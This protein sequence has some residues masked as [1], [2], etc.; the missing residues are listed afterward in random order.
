[1][2]GKIT[3]LGVTLF[4]FIFVSL[5]FHLQTKKAPW[6]DECYS[7]YGVWHDSFSEFY[8][9]MLTGINFSPPLYFLF[10]FCIQLV[11]PTSI[12]QLRIQSL[13]FIIIGIVLSFLL[14]RRFFGAT[15]AFVVTTLVASQSNL[16]LSQAQEARH[17]AMFFACGAWVLYIQSLNNLTVK[18]YKWF[19]FL[20]H[21]CLCQVHYIGI[22]F[23]GLVG[24]SYLTSNKDKPTIHRIPFPVFITWIISLP[25][26]LLLLSQQSSHLGN[27]PKPNGLSNL[28]SSYNDS[29]LFLTIIIPCLALTISS[30][31]KAST[32]TLQNEETG[33]SR[34]IMITSFLWILVPLLFWI[35]SHITPL[36]L[37][38]DRYFIPKEAALIFLVGFG[39]SFIFQKLTQQKFKSIFVLGTFGLSLVLILISTKRAAFGLN[40]DTNYHHSLIIKES[41]PKSEQPIILEGDP[42]YF[43]NAYL[44][45]NEYILLIEDKDLVKVYGQ[46][47]KKINF[48]GI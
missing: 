48:N 39:L 11:F 27:W 17:Y 35:I 12:E 45:R 33:C 2:K 31:S 36:N 13:V 28:I 8:D 15:C 9:S 6:V 40:K 29:I 5:S 25:V 47:S 24:L 7:Y 32:E 23:S 41:Y 42:K 20:G 1:M 19:T 30:N 3:Q 10:N 37:F 34:P 46:F 16:L 21:F 22:I 14:T 4:L 43:P 26:Y 18:K 38:V 44:N